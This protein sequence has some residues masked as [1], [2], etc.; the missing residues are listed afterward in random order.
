MDMDIQYQMFQLINAT[1][2]FMNTG[3][4][5][6]LEDFFKSLDTTCGEDADTEANPVKE[7][8]EL[9][10]KYS[11]MINVC[12][13]E[14]LDDTVR[15]LVEKI[16]EFTINKS[17]DLYSQMFQ[18]ILPIIKE[19]LYLE[20]VIDENN[21]KKVVNYPYIIKWCL[22]NDMLQQALTLYVECMS[23][24]YFDKKIIPDG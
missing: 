24:Y 17:N 22:D 20:H 9:M 7:I 21:D 16:D 4:A 18:S 5:K 23:K 14:K 13:L 3:S 2:E 11:E 10:K 6:Q 12:N 15:E 8:S 1:N 19:R